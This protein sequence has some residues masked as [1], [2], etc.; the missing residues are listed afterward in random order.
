MKNIVRYLK[1]KG[2]SSPE[3]CIILGSGLGI[4]VN[5]I[6]NKIT[7]KYNEIPKFFKTSVKGHKGE[8]VFG[9]IN[10]KTVLCASGRFHYYEGYTFTQVSSIIDIFN[11][12]N[13]KLCIITN[14][15]GSLNNK[16]RIGEFM[17]VNKFLD[18]SF[19]NST[20][21]YYHDVP[22]NKY[23]NLVKQCA[24]INNIKIHKG[25]YSF[26]TGPSYETYAEINEMISLG[27][28]AVGMS[29]FPEFLKCKKLNL[30]TII[31]SCLTNYGAG[32]IN[33]NKVKHSDVLKN[34]TKVKTKFNKLISAFIQNI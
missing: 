27:G 26:V 5:N 15:A 30:E 11:A 19:I 25:T 34:A 2:I 21:T 22:M 24:N 28:N 33:N 10:N 1:S 23:F 3:V 9:K 14:S 4:F 7:V 13:P 32:L 20:K 6:N 31:I 18:F 17:I 16:W 29:T 12:L 8:F